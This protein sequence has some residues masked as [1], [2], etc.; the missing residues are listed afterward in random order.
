M[1][2]TTTTTNTATTTRTAA[3]ATTTVATTSENGHPPWAWIRAVNDIVVNEPFES[4]GDMPVGIR[5]WLFLSDLCTVIFTDPIQGKGKILNK[6]ITHVLSTNEMDPRDV[7]SLSRKLAAAGIAH[8]A[9]SAHDIE[10]YDMVGNH[11]DECGGKVVVHCMAGHNR[12]G[13]IVTAALMMLERMTVLEAVK[14][15]KAQRGICLT[16]LS[17]QK[18]LCEL[19]QK[20]GLLGEKPRGYSDSEVTY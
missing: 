15:V 18:Q 16:N 17:F 20:E 4:K 13:L 10:G 14:R 3:A 1:E 5:P 7:H 11:L 8:K 9:V 6:G 2:E 19:A 12:S